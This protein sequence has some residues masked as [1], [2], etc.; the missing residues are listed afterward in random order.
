MAARKVAGSGRLRL[1][2]F[3]A[4]FLVVSAGVILRRSYGNRTSRELTALDARRAALVAER[5]RLEGEIRAASS[6]AR[7]QPLAEQRLQMKLPSEEQVILVP[8][9]APPNAAP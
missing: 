7:L 4:I 5:L 9:A 3:L 1:A 8:R 6:R 2:L